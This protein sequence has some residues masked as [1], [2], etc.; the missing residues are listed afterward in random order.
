MNNK[1]LLTCE[2]CKGKFC[3]SYD[4]VGPCLPIEIKPKEPKEHNA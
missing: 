3:P 1:P 4:L 2:I